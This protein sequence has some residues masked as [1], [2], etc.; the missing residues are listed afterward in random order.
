MSAAQAF[1]I[2]QNDSLP[3]LTRNLQLRA[4]AEPLDLTGASKVMFY[5]AASSGQVMVSGQ[6]SIVSATQGRVA[7]AWGAG[8]TATVGVF[9]AEF[10]VVWPASQLQTVP[11]AGYIS[12]RVLD[13]IA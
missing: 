1:Q 9:A 7:Y 11:N 2:K 4:T 6:A 10:E 5:L 12:V 13:D 8:E 3:P